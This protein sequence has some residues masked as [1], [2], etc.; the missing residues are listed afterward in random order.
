MFFKG[1]QVII[2]IT[3]LK[4]ISENKDYACELF[5]FVCLNI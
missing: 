1:E 2:Q 4:F 5:S 3:Y